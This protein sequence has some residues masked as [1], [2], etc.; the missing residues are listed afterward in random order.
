MFVEEEFT[1]E[2]LDKKGFGVAK[3]KNKIVLIERTLPGDTVKA[4]LPKK[5][6]RKIVKAQ[7]SEIISQKIKRIKPKCFY[8]SS[9]GG[10]KWQDISYENQLKLK[11]D[12]IVSSFTKLNLLGDI[13][14]PDIIPA[15]TEYFYRNKME[16]SFSHRRWITPEEIEKDEKYNKQFALGLHTPHTHDKIIDLKTCYLQTPLTEKLVNF[17]RTFCLENKLEPYHIYDDVGYLKFLVIKETSQT[18]QILINLVTKEFNSEVIQKL[19]E[20]L[21][22]EF[23]Q[24]TSFFNTINSGTGQ[25]AIGNETHLIFGEQVIVEKLLGM[26]FE[27]SPFSFFQPNTLAAENVYKCIIDLA[28]FTGSEAVL[29]LYSGVGS[30]S[31]SIAKNVKQVIGFELSEEAVSAA[32]RNKEINNIN[33]CEF[34][35]GDLKDAVEASSSFDQKIDLII[36]DPPRS[37]LHPKVIKKLIEMKAPTII[38]VSCNPLTQAEDLNELCTNGPYKIEV[39]QPIDMLPQTL[40]I[41][42]VVKLSL[43][44][45]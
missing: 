35:A 1:I 33:N 20:K 8:F 4:T 23:P 45:D 30:I 31:L 7:L 42:N 12:K 6:R 14:I 3:L 9:C 40:H 28:K 16:F 2:S 18:N 15:P 27:I 36:V 32:N 34:Y 29:D 44:N 21:K 22:E 24:I 43:K 37:G 17:V 39:I 26:N 10:C 13:T 38:Y 19:G 11:K 41:E 25:V 5:R